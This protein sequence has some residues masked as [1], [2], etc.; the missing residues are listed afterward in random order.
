MMDAQVEA[1]ARALAA[2]DALSALKRVALREDAT[3]LALRGIALAQLGELARARELLGSAA[4]AFGSQ[5]A[6]ARARCLAAEAEVALAQRDLRRSDPELAGAIRT[7]RAHGDRANAAYAQL[8]SVRRLLLL[9]RVDEAEVALRELE[10]GPLP[11]M[12]VASAELTLAQIASRRVR[13]AEAEAALER[14][15]HAAVRARVPALAAEIER[16]QR[17]LQAIAARVSSA[18]ETCELTLAGVE[19]LFESK[20]LLLDACRRE[21]RWRQKRVV[22]AR[23]PVLFEL[24]RALAESWPSEVPRAQLIARAFAARRSDDSHRARLRVELGRLRRELRGLANVRATQRGFVLEAESIAVLTPPSDDHDTALLALLADGA[25][26]S[27][28]ALALALGSSQRTVQRALA[29]LESAG[30][31]EAFGRGR[32]RR[33]L[34]SPL[35]GFATGLLLPGGLPIA[36]TPKPDG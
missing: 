25:R 17:E 8:V 2:G 22:L 21:L 28:S 19:H 18:G 9:G 35:S 30:K 31:V 7:L 20:Q 24:L 32:T 34:G 5:A 23:R 16:A 12:L 29:A 13:A 14:A 6:L 10:A 36:Y 27:T 4:Q 15:H 3:A 33:W 11:A 26:W 1:A